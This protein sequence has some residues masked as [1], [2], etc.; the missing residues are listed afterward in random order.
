MWEKKEENQRVPTF[1]WKMDTV[2]SSCI[3]PN[4]RKLRCIWGIQWY[5]TV[6]LQYQIL[7]SIYI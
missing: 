4:Q 6:E 1:M 7:K 2:D 5:S 3:I